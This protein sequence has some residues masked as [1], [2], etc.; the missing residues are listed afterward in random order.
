MSISNWPKEDQPREKLLTYGANHL[1]HAEL[2]AIFLN[3]GT[4]DKTAVDI[5]KELLQEFGNLKNLL[6]ANQSELCK[7]KGVGIKKYLLLQAAIELGQRYQQEDIK[8]GD[9]L[10]NSKQTQQ[11]LAAHLSHKKEEVFACLFL[12]NRNQLLAFE[13]LFHGSL[14]EAAVYPRV[15]IKRALAHNTAKIILAHNHPSG[16]AIPSQADKD[17]TQLLKEA[18]KLIEVTL[19]DHIIIG[20]THHFSFA[21]SMCI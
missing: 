20:K 4:K 7:K 21:E 9:T 5:A 16:L 6:V 1:T 10:N 2:L 3:T 14:T 12:D 15:L 11:F 19:I 8:R 18:L 17:I 13:E